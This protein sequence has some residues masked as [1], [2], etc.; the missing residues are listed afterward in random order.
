M[1]AEHRRSMAVSEM[2]ESL[3]ESNPWNFPWKSGTYCRWRM[4]VPPVVVVHLE[5]DDAKH[6]PK[7][8]PQDRSLQGT[9]EQILDVPVLEKTERLVEAL[10]T[11]PQDRIQQRTVEHIAADTSV[12]QDV[13]EPAEFSKAFSQDRVQPR[14]GGQII[15]NPA[16]PLAEKIVEVP[17]IQ[18]EEKTRQGVNMCVQHVVNAVEVEKSEIIEETVQRMKPIIQEKINQEIKRIEV[19]P[20]QFMDKAIDIP[21]VAQ[22]Q[23]PQVHVV[24]KTVEDPQFEI[25]EKTVENPETVAQMQ[26]VEEA[27][28]IPQLQLDGTQTSESLN[29]AFLRRVT[30]AETGALSTRAWLVCWHAAQHTAA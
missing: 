30:Q 24:K 22:R 12:P 18:T 23:V 3:Q 13:E 14:F 25:V 10:K 7:I 11:I 19:P 28:E 16:I 6:S 26:D 27:V 4:G 21:V 2:T 5:A 17:V 29:T 8:V 1:V 20:L 15:E 9:V